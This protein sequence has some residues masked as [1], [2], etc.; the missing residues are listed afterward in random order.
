MSNLSPRAG[1]IPPI[2]KAQLVRGGG[3]RGKG[4]SMPA[5]GDYAEND[6]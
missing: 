5:G 6:G 2:I 4:V 3:Y 1:G